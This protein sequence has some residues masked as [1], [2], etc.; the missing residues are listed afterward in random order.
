VCVEAALGGPLEHHEMIQYS[1]CVL[2]RKQE[3]QEQQH[4]ACDSGV[5]QGV[6]L[7]VTVS[8]KTEILYIF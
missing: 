7:G 3:Q 5:L 2:L 4:I 8:I 1:I 6:V